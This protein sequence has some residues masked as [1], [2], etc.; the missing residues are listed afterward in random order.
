MLKI[1][2][3]LVNRKSTE[4]LESKVVILALVSVLLL[5]IC[6]TLGKEPN[7]SRD[8][9]VFKMSCIGGIMKHLWCIN[10]VVC[11]QNKTGEI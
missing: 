2:R 7:P 5:A 6:M 10:S 1:I 11:T 9:S 4:L 3:D 8:P